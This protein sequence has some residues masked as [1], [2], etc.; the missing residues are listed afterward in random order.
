MVLQRINHSIS[1]DVGRLLTHSSIYWRV[2][3]LETIWLYVFIVFL[4]LLV[5]IPEMKIEV[6]NLFH[7]YFAPLDLVTMQLIK[8][9]LHAYPM[10]ISHMRLLRN[11]LWYKRIYHAL[12]LKFRYAHYTHD[13]Y[14][15]IIRVKIQYVSWICAPRFED[16][17]LW[18]TQCDLLSTVF[19]FAPLEPWLTG[20][21]PNTS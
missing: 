18:T 16:L 20:R 15:Y 14:V 11:T 10:F 7:S 5:P 21:C 6:T 13:I 12:F 3:L 1:R 4:R 17:L 19:K 8:Y 2:G 9:I